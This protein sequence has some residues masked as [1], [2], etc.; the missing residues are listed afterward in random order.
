[1]YPVN[2]AWHNSSLLTA[3]SQIDVIHPL[4]KAGGHLRLW[5]DV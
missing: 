4:V 2:N 1:M 3:E 5:L